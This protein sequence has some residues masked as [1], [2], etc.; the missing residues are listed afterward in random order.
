MISRE[1]SEE[2]LIGR[3]SSTKT[4][5]EYSLFLLSLTEQYISSCF[6][7]VTDQMMK[8]FFYFHDDDATEEAQKVAK[9]FVAVSVGFLFVSLR[10]V[11]PIQV[12]E[13]S[14]K[15]NARVC[16][17]GFALSPF[18]REE[19]AESVTERDGFRRG[20]DQI[21]INAERDENYLFP[22]ARGKSVELR[23][24]QRFW[25]QFSF[26]FGERFSHGI[27]VFV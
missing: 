4:T 15:K 5:L 14:Y 26:A 27:D 20:D 2:K 24:Q 22:Q 12:R 8:K 25:S 7:R 16:A 1:F 19:R 23:L 17:R 3:F 10:R 9:V 11:H 18:Q 6:Q 21:A 13:K